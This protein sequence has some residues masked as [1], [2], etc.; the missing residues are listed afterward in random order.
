M[1]TRISR[2]NGGVVLFVSGELDAV[3]SDP[4]EEQLGDLLSE[5]ISWLILDLANVRYISSAGLR[6]LLGTAKRMDKTGIFSLSRPS[7][8]VRNV[9]EMVGFGTILTIYD[10]LESARRDVLPRED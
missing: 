10:D 3:T 1:D 5:K 7:V 8:E 9:L 4:L 2:E 6:V